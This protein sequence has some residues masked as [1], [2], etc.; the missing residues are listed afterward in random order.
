MLKK[1]TFS[2][3]LSSFSL[4]SGSHWNENQISDYVHY[5]ELQRRSTWH[6]LS[7]IK[8]NGDESILDVGCGDGRNTAW[9]AYLVRKGNV[10]GIDPSDAMLNWAKKQYHV[11]EFPNLTFVEGDANRLPKQTFDVITSFF[12]LHVVQ[13]KQSAIQGFY[14]QLKDDGFVIAV[15]PP[16]PKNVEYTD[17][18]LETMQDVRW[19]PYFKNFHSTFLR[20]DLESYIRYF[21]NAGFHILHAKE[22]PSV[23]PF[24]NREEAV[25]WFMGTFPHVHYL[26]KQLGKVFFDDAIDRYI[27]KRPSAYSQ[28]GVLYFYWGH[29]EIIAQKK[30][31]INK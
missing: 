29:Y 2:L 24:V 31:G 17:A 13:E 20:E 28:D 4:L 11:F 15:I 5:S 25:N 3:I 16:P 14:D 6:L 30:V 26:P 10:I 21:E 27:Q 12:S 1:I 9:M 22:V 23:D 19:K 7:Q 8:F 18:L